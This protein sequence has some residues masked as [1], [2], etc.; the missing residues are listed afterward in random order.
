MGKALVEVTK[1]YGL[2][3]KA[4]DS[5]KGVQLGLSS[6][7]AQ[8]SR[9]R[10]HNST[11]FCILDIDAKHPGEDDF[12]FKDILYAD[13]NQELKSYQTSEIV[14]YLSMSQCK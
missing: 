4:V 7:A 5:D 12:R 8:F 6:D 14:Q 1:S 9:E 2:E 11:Y 13:R 10:G 3:S